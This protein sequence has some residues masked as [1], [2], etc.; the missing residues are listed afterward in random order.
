MAIPKSSR[1]PPALIQRFENGGDRQAGGQIELRRP[2]DLG[3]ADVLAGHLRTHA[4]D[5]KREIVELAH[6]A[7]IHQQNPLEVVEAV[8]TI[9]RPEAFNR[10]MGRGIPFRSHNARNVSGEIDPSI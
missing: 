6:G 9:Q 7:H 5:D 2:G 1:A 8:V 10:V 4:M 3:V